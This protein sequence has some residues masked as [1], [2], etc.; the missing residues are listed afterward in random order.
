MLW[1]YTYVKRVFL[2][3]PCKSKLY[4]ML[5]TR[6][7]ISTSNASKPQVYSHWFCNYKHAMASSL[8]VITPIIDT[9][10]AASTACGI[11][12]FQI[13]DETLGVWRYMTEIVLLLYFSQI[14]STLYYCT[15]IYIVRACL[16]EHVSLR[17]KSWQ[18][19]NIKTDSRFT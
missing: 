9:N 13:C 3:K 18:N 8:W 16:I 4:S 19:D 11:K 10:K 15:L 17:P 1:R 14:Q 2:L 7:K 5:H 6:H 12:E